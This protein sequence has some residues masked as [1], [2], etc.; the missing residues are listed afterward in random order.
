MHSDELEATMRRYEAASDRQV[1]P[2]AYML[3]RLDGR[4]FARL[5]RARLDLELPLDLRIRDIM[6]ATA[7]HLMHCGLEVSYA[8]TQSDEVS[9]LFHRSEPVRDVQRLA[10]RLAG[11]ASAKITLLLG[12]LA[13]FDCRVFGLPTAESV[14]EYFGWRHAEATREALAAHCR[15]ALRATGA[16]ADAVEDRLREADAA[17]RRG[18]LGL[19]GTD[20][21]RLP[22]WQRHGAGLHWAR[23]GAPVAALR[24][25]LRV[26]LELPEAGAYAEFVRAQVEQADAPET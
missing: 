12:E 23:T 21:D 14:V 8:H 22:P 10:S 13:S 16:D 9:L 7:D 6:I 25:R 4:G 26:E 11:E 2:D 3:A 1:P 5:A 24:R 20:F 18:L 17:D 19:L 15:W